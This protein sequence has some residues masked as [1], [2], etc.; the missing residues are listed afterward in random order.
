[1]KPIENT[2][3]V[4]RVVTSLLGKATETLASTLVSQLGQSV[5]IKQR[6]AKRQSARQPAKAK[7]SQRATLA[8]GGSRR[9]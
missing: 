5:G 7:R 4:A 6:A 2:T 8:K 3:G 1:M 9:G